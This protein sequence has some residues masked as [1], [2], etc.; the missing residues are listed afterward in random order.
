MK[1]KFLRFYLIAKYSVF[2]SDLEEDDI[3]K[4]KEP[5]VIEVDEDK[6]TSPTNIQ[7]PAEI[8]IHFLAVAAKEISRNI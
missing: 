6:N 3:I 5:I 7:T 8:P 1:F 4:T 2:K